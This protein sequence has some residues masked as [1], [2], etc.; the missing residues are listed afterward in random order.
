MMRGKKGSVGRQGGSANLSPRRIMPY[1]Q[2]SGAAAPGILAEANRIIR[3]SIGE[4]KKQYR[5]GLMPLLAFLLGM[6]SASGAMMLLRLLQ[7]M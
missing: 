2:R 7:W 4:R 6:L 5:Q 1:S 3:E